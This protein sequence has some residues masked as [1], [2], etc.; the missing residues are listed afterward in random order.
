MKK[1]DILQA[2]R[3]VIKA[4]EELAIPYYIGGSIASSIYGLARATID[5][6]V[7]AAIR[8]EHVQPLTNALQGRYF[9]DADMIFEKAKVK[10]Q[11]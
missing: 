9:I 8:Q 6:D 1:A 11:K 5:V 10:R 4:F 3:P 2:L 7:A